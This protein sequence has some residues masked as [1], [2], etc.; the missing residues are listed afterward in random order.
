MV[1]GTQVTSEPAA[2]EG[3]EENATARDEEV[4]S[5]E[6]EVEMPTLNI[7]V[8]IGLLV[9]VTVVCGKLLYSSSP[10]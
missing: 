8:T 6:S 4:G 1:P 7:Y 2:M 10:F 9:V 5:V 3:A